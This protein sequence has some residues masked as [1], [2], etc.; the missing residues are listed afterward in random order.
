VR[1]ADADWTQLAH[2]LFSDPQDERAEAIHAF[3]FE[4]ALRDGNLPGSRPSMLP[5]AELPER[6][7]QASRYQADHVPA[8]LA[9]IGCREAAM[10]EPGRMRFSG[11]E[12][13]ALAR[14]EHERWSA[15]QRLDGWTYGAVRD[16]AARL[17]PFLKP[18][19]ELPPEIQDR[20]RMPVR[21]MPAQL[22]RIGHGVKRDAVVTL[23]ANADAEPVFTFGMLFPR[24]LAEI[25]TRYPDRSLVLAS[26]LSNSLERRAAGIALARGLPLRALLPPDLAAPPESE[27]LLAQASDLMAITDGGIAELGTLHVH[28]GAA[29]PVARRL[30]QLTADGRVQAAPWL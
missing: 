28:V 30:V 13:D 23:T 9:M 11:G 29:P 3:Y 27:A 12:V 18:Y 21:Q 10:A 1:A 15:V 8:K 22:A 7:R 6:F 19:D 24:L 16:D 17:T 5:W 2:S 14:V 4:A 26:A 20:D 25:A